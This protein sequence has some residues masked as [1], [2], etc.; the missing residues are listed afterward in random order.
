MGTVLYRT[1]PAVGSV[2]VG[3]LCKRFLVSRF[4][5]KSSLT[6]RLLPGP[7]S[8]SRKLLIG[9]LLLA[10]ADGGKKKG[11]G[12]LS[13]TSQPKGRA[14]DSKLRGLLCCHRACEANRVEQRDQNNT[15]KRQGEIRLFGCECGCKCGYGSMVPSQRKANTLSL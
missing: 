3:T 15:K 9:G 1:I 10:S 11:W 5:C 12:G 6:C 4:P 2:S 14:R 7:G 13:P 8:L